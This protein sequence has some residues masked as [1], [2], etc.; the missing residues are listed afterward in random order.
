MK[1]PERPPLGPHS[2]RDD[3]WMAES[4]PHRIRHLEYDHG[5]PAS[6]IDPYRRGMDQGTSQ[7]LGRIHER[8]PHTDH[9]PEPPYYLEQRQSAMRHVAGHPAPAEMTPGVPLQFTSSGELDRAQRFCERYGVRAGDFLRQAREQRVPQAG[10]SMLQ[11]IVLLLQRLAALDPF[12]SAVFISDQEMEEA[13]DVWLTSVAV[14]GG[15][16]LSADRRPEEGSTS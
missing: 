7:A 9:Q 14:P 11:V 1:D 2:L 5:C 10:P 4:V 6:E 3:E 15:F 13:D 12:A 16:F 8:Y